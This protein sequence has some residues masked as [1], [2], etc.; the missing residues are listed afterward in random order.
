[1]QTTVTVPMPADEDGRLSALYRY[2]IL[3]TPPEAAFDGVVR[4][5]RDLLDAPVA[6]I[7]LVDGDRQWFKARS[8]MEA[9]ETPR[10][11]AFCAHAILEREVMEIPDATRDPRFA[12]NPMVT[13][14]PGVRF[15]AGAPLRTSDGYALGTLC[16]YDFRPRTL[17]PAQREHLK[18]LAGMVI[19]EMELRRT[20]RDLAQAVDK[21]ERAHRV[22]TQ[23]M[24]AITHDLRSPL[25]A[26]LGFAEMIVDLPSASVEDCRRW[27]GS[28]VAA[29]GQMRFLVDGLL[30][31]AAME[32]GQLRLDLGDIP[33]A[34]LFDAALLVVE[35]RARQGGIRLDRRIPADLPAIRA[36]GRRLVQVLVNLLDNAVKFTP[37]GGRVALAAVLQP[38]E[39]E[40]TV[41][42]TGPGIAP[43]DLERVLQPYGQTA[44]GRAQVG[45]G[46]GL[47]LAKAMIEALGGHF[48]LESVP[49]QGVLARISVPLAVKPCI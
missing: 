26:I 19:D 42:D 33:L 28:I 21:A 46:L 30:D 29:G 8:G 39:V 49:G 38:R 44:A 13:G 11:I 17:S 15:Y 45:T 20:A 1:M 41:S 40:I 12:D 2:A 23:V 9:T 48:R 43:E 3:D 14:A 34:P 6:T 4:L 24:A 16:A 7:S 18:H 22:R 37:A 35:G 5:L 27:A 10:S 25:N 32:A 47:P 36:D 31:M